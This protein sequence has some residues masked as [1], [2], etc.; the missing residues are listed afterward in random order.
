MLIIPYDTETTGLP[1]WKNPSEA[2]HQPHLVEL[3]ALLID[4]LTLSVRDAFSA[5]IKPDGWTWDTD[6]EAFKAHG[7]TVEQAM[8]EGIPEAWALEQFLALHG[9]ADLRVGHNE[10]FDARILRIAL[11]RY[12][13]GPL[14]PTQEDRDG[15]ADRFK[16]A[17]AY[18]TCNSAKPIV[19]LPP[20]PAMIKSGKK[21]WFK[22]PN[23]NEA[24]QF[25]FGRPHE[26][27]HRA[28][29]DAEGCARVY[30]AIVNPGRELPE[31]LWPPVSKNGD[32]PDLTL[33]PN[34]D[35]TMQAERGGTPE[36]KLVPD[37]M[38]QLAAGAMSA[39]NVGANIQGIDPDI[40]GGENPNY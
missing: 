19:K 38:A 13:M 24:H 15:L 18:C 26:G 12:G 32:V 5:I 10:S 4:P 16:E 14:T 30:F 8:D 22:P 9:Q 31:R 40:G 35:Q 29:S 11:K 20:T 33:S 28:M 36:P 6:S 34:Y 7:I 3:A 27:A 2:P 39:V 17:P 21:H 1:D 25:F 37:P 23:L